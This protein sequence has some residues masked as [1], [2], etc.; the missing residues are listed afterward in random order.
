[1][2]HLRW[3]AETVLLGWNRIKV[4]EN[5]GAIAVVPVVPVVTFLKLNGLT[6]LSHKSMLGIL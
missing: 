1:M 3:W 6:E 4:S 5:M 2:Q